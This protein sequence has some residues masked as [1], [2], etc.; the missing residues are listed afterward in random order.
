MHQLLKK[1]FK[2]A[3]LLSA[4][5]A[6]GAAQAFPVPGQGTW[7]KTLQARDI[8]KDGETDAFYDTAL[9]ITWLRAGSADNLDWHT[10]KEWAENSNFFGL[11]GWSLP[12]TV[13]KRNDGCNFSWIGGTD[14][15]YNPDSSVATGSQMAHLFF[16]SLGNKSYFAP[17]TGDPQLGWGLSNTGDFQNLQSRG[18]WSGTEYAPNSNFAWVFSL[19]VGYQD[20]DNKSVGLRALAVRP[21][22]VTAAVPEPQTWALALVG[23]T[24]VLLARRRRA[25]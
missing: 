14:C 11:S 17:G 1:T 24:G 16:Q 6:A 13:D 2:T 10:A 25:L 22:D 7:E 5:V 8:D 18:Y 4:L 23:L 20:V 21:G 12:T 15:G 3:A 19:S 9:N